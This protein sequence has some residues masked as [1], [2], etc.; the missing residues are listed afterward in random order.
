MLI[1]CWHINTR[2][3]RKYCVCS[4]R[5]WRRK[6]R[7]WDRATW[8]WAKTWA[9]RGSHWMS[10][11]PTVNVCTARANLSCR[12]STRGCENRSKCQRQH[13][14]TPCLVHLLFCYVVIAQYVCF[15][16]LVVSIMYCSHLM[17]QI[18]LR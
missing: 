2:R 9:M 10:R 4:W 8:M 6:W 12:T 5:K 14:R 1:P 11:A 3:C 15:Q 18:K 17:I 7:T 16:Q 13:H